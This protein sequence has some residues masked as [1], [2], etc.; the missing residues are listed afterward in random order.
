MKKHL[1]L[2]GSTG[3]IGQQ[4]LSIVNKFP[5][6]FSIAGLAAGSNISLLEKQAR[7]FKPDMVAVANKDLVLELEKNLKDTKVKVLGG[8]EGLLEMIGTSR[9]DWVVNALVGFSG[10]R[11]TVLALEEGKSIALANKETLVAGGDL[12]MSLAERK[13]LDI[14]PID[15]EHSAIFQCLQGEKDDKIYKIF[16]TASGG[17]FRGYTQE[18][19]SRVNLKQALKHPNWVM[20]KKITIDSATL[21]NKGLEVLE[22]KALFGLDLEQIEVVIHPQ[23]IIH[24][25][26]EFIDGAV[27]AQMGE[28]D[29]GVPIQYAL[30]YPERWENDFKRLDW[31]EIKSLTFEQPDTGVFKCLKLAYEAG[32]AG[33]TMPAVMNAANEIA[34]ELFLKEQISFLDIPCIIEEAM[35]KHKVTRDPSLEDIVRVD[36]EIRQQ[37]SY[38]KRFFGKN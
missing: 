21:M 16:L 26:V 27:L 4:T 37:A 36:L 18:G 25:M 24:S 7:M 33:G 19:L 38:F 6:S 35:H 31:R 28:P 10:L 5:E 30:T 20:G 34:V 32:E 1:L 14:V 29:M 8:E 9:T 12:I 15:S 13:G 23:S 17:P 3:S 22:A 11:P 2:L